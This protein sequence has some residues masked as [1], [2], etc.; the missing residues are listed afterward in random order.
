MAYNTGTTPTL[1]E[2]ITAGFNPAMFSTQ[3]FMHTMSNLVV[4]DTCNSEFRK[5]LQKGY[6]VT[7][8]VM[9]EISTTEV[10]PGTKA[11]ASNAAGTPATI[12]VDKWRYSAVE[13]SKM[14]QIENIVDYMAKGAKSVGYALAKY[15]DTTLG[16]LF[17]TLN[18]SSV[19]GTDGTAFDEDLW[20]SIVQTLDEADVP[21]EDRACITDPSGRADM[22][23]IDSFIKTDYVREAVVPT[24]KIGI[25][26][27]I[28]IRITNNLTAATTG[29]YGVIKH[30]D[31]I[32]FVMQKDP[33][34]EVVPLPAEFH[35]L[36]IGDVIFGCAETRDAFG[37]PFYTRHA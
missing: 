1:A 22:R 19:L 20:L 17:S 6:T 32:S 8:P 26:D 30:R 29:N 28:G 33:G 2:L 13:I 9:S 3:V 34:T 27:G 4:G 16:A 14:S 23:K 25:I 5:E 12:T 36:V 31:A 15:V 35:T 10:T 18:S 21:L 24:G 7:I 11:S 37:V